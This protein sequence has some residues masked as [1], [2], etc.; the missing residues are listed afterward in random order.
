MRTS[1]FFKGIAALVVLFAIAPTAI[2]DAPCD[3]GFR[4]VTPAER[5]RITSALQLAQSALPP[6]PEGW[7]LR[8]QE[9]FSIPSSLC[10]DRENLPWGY[11]FGRSYG[12]VGDYAA[13][14]KVMADAAAAA[15]A[16]RAKNQSRLDAMQAQM[17]SIMQQQMALNQKKDYD[18]AQKLQPQLEKVQADYE[19]LLTAGNQQI[20][21]A[22]REY[23]RDL[24]MNISV[25]INE[26]TQR[27]GRNVTNLALPAGALT[28][29]RWQ[30]ED[31]ED[32]GDYALI[33][34]G[35]WKKGANGAWQPGVRTGVPPSGPHAVAVHVMADRER[36]ASVVQKIDF[37]KVAAILK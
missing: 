19:M 5:A 10:K 29:V 4:D 8:S 2:G 20:E 34:F 18:G 30:A 22:G 1:L 36:L 27:P 7:Q 14:E 37:T 35:S 26:G 32:T 11:G 16:D 17:M 9:D 3:K 31:P 25:R 12:Q 24:E 33:L 23:E 6:A 15:A 13:R 21:A 28:A